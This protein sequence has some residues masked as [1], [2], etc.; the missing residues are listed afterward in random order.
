MK[1]AEPDHG[2]HERKQRVRDDQVVGG[3]IPGPGDAA[4]EPG[5]PAALLVSTRIKPLW[6]MNGWS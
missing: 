4:R 1:Q 5:W 3:D 2:L 6:Y